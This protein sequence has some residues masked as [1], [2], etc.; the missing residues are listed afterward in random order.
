L[1]SLILLLSFSLWGFSYRELQISDY[2]DIILEI[3]KGKIYTNLE[4]IH[5]TLGVVTVI[6]KIDASIE[7]VWKLIQSDN[8]KIYPDILEKQILNQ[9]GNRIIK[10]SLL[11]FPWPLSDRWTVYD[12]EINEKIFAKEWKEIG[13]D[14]KINR[15][16]IRLFPYRNNSTIMIFKLSFDPGLK[17]VPEWAIELGMKYKAPSIID[18]IRYCLKY[19][20]E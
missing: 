3:E 8:D 7:I 14:I 12:E 20:N 19:C 10:K 11:N 17:F 2:Q 16:A 6:G 13:G 5:N 4:K 18:R 1:V 9:E 15:G